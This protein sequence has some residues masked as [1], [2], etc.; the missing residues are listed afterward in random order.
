[1]RQEEAVG[2]ESYLVLGDLELGDLAPA[3]RL[4]VWPGQV[5]SPLWACL[6]ICKRG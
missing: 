2:S 6:F 5:A 3:H 1:M 4:T